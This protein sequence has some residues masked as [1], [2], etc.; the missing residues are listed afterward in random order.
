MLREKKTLF[1]SPK[2]M[3]AEYFENNRFLEDYVVKLKNV[4]LAEVLDW[5]MST[6]LNAILLSIKKENRL[7][8]GI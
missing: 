8:E 2:I 7:L 5:T 3:Q 6:L 1:L 4:F